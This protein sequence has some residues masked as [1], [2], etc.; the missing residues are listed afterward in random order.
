LLNIK[1]EENDLQSESDYNPNE[2]VDRKVDGTNFAQN[3]V[4]EINH[5]QGDLE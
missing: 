3:G 5:D 4:C 2:I 1:S